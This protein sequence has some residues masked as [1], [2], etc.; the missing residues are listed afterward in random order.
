MRADP[1][2][3]QPL[4]DQPHPHHRITYGHDP[5]VIRLKGAL[6]PGCDDQ[7]PHHLYQD[8]EPVGHIVGVEGRGKPSEVHPRPPD[9]KEHHGERQQYVPPLAVRPRMVHAGG[10]LGDRDDEAEVVEQLQGS[11]RA[12]VFLRV[13]RLHGAHPGSRGRGVVAHHDSS[14]RLFANDQRHTRGHPEHHRMDAE[15]QPQ[16]IASHDYSVA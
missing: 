13:T 6:H 5:K 4:S 7:Q 14:T 8:L 2:R 16:A 1:G 11:R 15:F 10:G 12:V 9:G 3:A